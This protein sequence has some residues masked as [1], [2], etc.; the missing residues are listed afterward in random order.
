[1]KKS[2]TKRFDIRILPRLSILN[3]YVNTYNTYYSYVQLDVLTDQACFCVVYMNYNFDSCSYVI[4]IC[5]FN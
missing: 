2:P 4:C 3:T 1:M 5:V